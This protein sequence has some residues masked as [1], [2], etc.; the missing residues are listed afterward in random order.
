M[1]IG[2]SEAVHVLAAGCICAVACIP[3]VLGRIITGK[4]AAGDVTAGDEGADNGRTEC[5]A[6]ARIG[7]VEDRGGDVAGRIEAVDWDSAEVDDASVFVGAQPAAG[8]QRPTVDGHGVER[9]DAQR[10]QAGI[11]CHR[12]IAE[13]PV[14]RGAAATEFGVDAGLGI[15]SRVVIA[16]LDR[17]NRPRLDSWRR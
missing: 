16:S 7:S 15:F 2:S 10:P 9:A 17:A 12:G 1:L 13:E 11:R 4:A 14:L 6:A 8:A 5:G 3:I